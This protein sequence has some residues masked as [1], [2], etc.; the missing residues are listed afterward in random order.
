MGSMVNSLQ[1]FDSL[2]SIYRISKDQNE[3]CITAEQNSAEKP[4]THRTVERIS[5]V[6]TPRET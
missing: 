2:S 4:L 6:P 5:V 1:K 3:Q